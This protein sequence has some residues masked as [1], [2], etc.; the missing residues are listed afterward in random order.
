MTTRL[1]INGLLYLISVHPVPPPPPVEG[2]P[3][4]LNL[5]NINM[6]INFD[7]A[8]NDLLAGMARTM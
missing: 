6:T 1:N 5:A 2:L 3:F 7:I 4:L 8:K